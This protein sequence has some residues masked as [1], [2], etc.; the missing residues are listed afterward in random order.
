MKMNLDGI[1]KFASMIL[2]AAGSAVAA[3]TVDAQDTL[4]W[5]SYSK[6]DP[7]TDE[8]EVVDAG[9]WRKTRSGGM[10]PFLRIACRKDASSGKRQ[11]SAMF[12]VDVSDLAQGYTYQALGQSF[13]VNIELKYRIDRM[14]PVEMIGAAGISVETDRTEWDYGTWITGGQGARGIGLHMPDGRTFAQRLSVGEESAVIRLTVDSTQALQDSEWI[15]AYRWF[16]EEGE[17]D[18][19]GFLSF[20]RE[21]TRE[22]SLEGAAEAIRP[23]LDACPR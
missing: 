13:A 3:G 19:P 8:L 22:I 4:R 21:E 20:T 16:H 18:F 12:I 7:F 6:T 11:F 9:V 10:M 14:L 5:E 23:V 15:K 1:A 2:V 17:E